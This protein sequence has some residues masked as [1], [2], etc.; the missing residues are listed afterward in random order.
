MSYASS[1]NATSYVAVV[2]YYD[3]AMAA[4]AEL[5]V[6]TTGFATSPTSTPAHTVVAPRIITPASVRRD[7]FDVGVTG[8]ASRVGYGELLLRNDDGGLDWLTGVSVDGRTVRL[9]V[10]PDTGAEFPA[11]YTLLLEAVAE[12]P[13]LTLAEVRVRLRDRQS[14]TARQL[15]PVKYA[16]SNVLPNG[17]EG[18]TSDLQGKPKPVLYGWCFN[19]APVLCNTSRLVYQVNDGPVRDVTAVYDSGA[20]LS[21]G[22]DYADDTEMLS[23]QPLPGSFRVW[24][25]GGY[26]RLGST[27]IG[28]VTADAVEGQWPV[29]RTAGQVFRRVLV[30]RAGLDPSA[31]STADVAA[32]DAVQPGTVGLYLDDE[33][34]VAGALDLL[35]QSVGAWWGADAAGVLRLQRLEAPVA[36]PALVLDGDRIKAGSLRRVPL[37]RNGLPAHRV[38]VRCVPNW[39]VQTNGLVGSVGPAR[40]ARLAQPFQD[41]VQEDPA[42]LV[43][44]LLAPE[45]VVDTLLAC[46]AVGVAEAGRLL[47]LYGVQRDRYEVTVRLPGAALAQ[48]QLGTVV[49][50]QY[51]RFGL[52]AGRLL[53]VLG[54]QLDPVADEATLTLWG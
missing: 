43:Q 11:G 30:E 49:Q 21:R 32:L 26:F 31:V 37:A 33:T 15:Q 22:E 23:V 42:V 50:L 9:Y 27:A 4:E 36:P 6:G 13:E 38:T 46:R 54:Y 25:D 48:V 20:L 24:K 16:G 5:L 3:P 2:T 19:I 29:D 45:L 34:T 41:A 1:R 47:G 10:A 28:Q 52:D 18:I 39:T 7:L 8:G 44:H 51:S 35:A 40:R 12:Q 53:R 14:F 17:L